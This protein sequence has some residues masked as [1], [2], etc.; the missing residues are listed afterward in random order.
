[1]TDEQRDALLVAAV[2]YG[3]NGNGRRIRERAK[4]Q[5]QEMAQRIGVTTSCLWRW[6]YGKRR[7]RDEGAVKWAQELMFL[8]LDQTRVAA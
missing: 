4:V 1:M 2:R 8:E 7:P 6:E 3:K 5:Q